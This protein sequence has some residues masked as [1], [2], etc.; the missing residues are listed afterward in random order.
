MTIEVAHVN[1]TDTYIDLVKNYDFYPETKMLF[2]DCDDKQSYY[3][4]INENV[5][6]VRIMEGSE[7]GYLEGH[8]ETR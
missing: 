4:P 5:K 3:I 2:V 6:R 1:G 7:R 8:D